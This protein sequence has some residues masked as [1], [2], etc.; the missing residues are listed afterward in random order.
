[1]NDDYY[2]EIEEVVSKS[3]KH[4]VVLD[5]EI[6]IDLPDQE[7]FDAC[8]EY[9]RGDEKFMNI[10]LGNVSKSVIQKAVIDAI[11]QMYRR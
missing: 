4:R 5:V 11:N 3:Q 6:P 9:P 1:M 2:S 10:V 8:R 7:A